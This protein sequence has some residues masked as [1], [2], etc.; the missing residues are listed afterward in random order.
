MGTDIADITDVLVIGGGYAGL[1]VGALLAHAGYSVR[2]LEQSKV[3]GGRAGYVERDGFLLEY[4]LHDNRFASQ[5]AAAAVFSK[6]GRELPFIESEDPVL[7]R[8][9]GFEPLPNSV[10]RILKSKKFSTGEKLTAARYLARLVLGKPEKRYEQ[11]M[12][13]FLEGCRSAGIRELMTVLSGIGIIAPDLKYAS[14]GEFAAFL[15]Q[16]LKAKAKVGYPAGGTRTIIEGL[17]EVLE[18][19]GQ[20]LTGT[21]VEK[22]VPKK[23]K[24]TQ[25]ATRTNTY[26]ARA[27][28]SAVP[29]QQLPEL[30][31]NKDIPKPFVKAARSL[32]PTA[33]ISLD[34]ALSEPIS[35]ERGLMVTARPVSMGQF[36]SNID[37]GAAPAGKQLLSW[38]YPLPL[39]QVKEREKVDREEGRL[40]ETLGEM[41]PGIWE[42]VEWERALHLQM[43]DGFLPR[44]GQARPDRPDFRL[45]GL[46]NFFVAGDGTR[47]SGTGGDTAFYSA[48][49]VA[50]LVQEYLKQCE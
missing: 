43:V 21:R 16:A 49:H 38:Y 12:E 47:A 17:R 36:T 24:V 41:F 35:D 31:G 30:F 15:K 8:D 19:G 34:L 7:W 40:R 48:I 3:T 5:G 28:I 10:P 33:G 50:K 22:L 23:G 11:S 13:E 14:T 39:Q 42:K 4:G 26:S 6:L 2:L 37:P 20:I 25:V 18:T 32:V 45:K 44:P 29:V 1:A 9:G 46:E 27:V